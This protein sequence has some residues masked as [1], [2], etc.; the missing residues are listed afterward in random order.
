MNV[1]RLTQGH[2]NSARSVAESLYKDSFPEKWVL[3][4]QLRASHGIC[5]A[6]HPGLSSHVFCELCVYGLLFLSFQSPLILE[7]HVNTSELTNFSFYSSS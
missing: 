5:P 6:I 7:V 3:K 2:L 4:S 1:Q